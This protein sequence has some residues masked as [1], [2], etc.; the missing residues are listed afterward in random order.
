MKRISSK[1]KWSQYLSA[2]QHNSQKY[3]RGFTLISAFSVRRAGPALPDMR[4]QP[5][6]GFTLIELL[7]TIAVFSILAVV[8]TDL[9]TSFLQGTNKAQVLA[10]VKQNGQLAL[11]K[12][13][14]YIRSSTNVVLSGTNEI[15]LTQRS[16]GDVTV[17]FVDGC[18][19]PGCGG[20]KTNG[21]I[22]TVTSGTTQDLTNTDTVNGI[23][24]ISATFSVTSSGGPQI[25]QIKLT[26]SQAVSAP[27]RKDFVAQVDLETTA[28][29]RT[30]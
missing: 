22:E 24:V 13:E 8:G 12:A 28:T 27:S 7:I 25:V 9:F 17:R 26:L 23:D 11:E 2:L 21:K 20:P 4:A 29:T 5:Q 6:K 15:N 10:E 18:R 30:Y 3:R 1:S 19:P 16:G 14:R